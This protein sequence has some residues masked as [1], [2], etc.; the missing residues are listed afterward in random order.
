MTFTPKPVVLQIVQS[1]AV[2]AVV[3]NGASEQLT[4]QQ[5][6]PNVFRDP[7]IVAEWPAWLPAI[8]KVFAWD[9]E[10]NAATVPRGEV[11]RAED[12]LW[13]GTP[14]SSM[15]AEPGDWIVKGADGEPYPVSAETFAHLFDPA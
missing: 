11:W 13:I 3:W 8:S 9:H 12:T 6:D 15:K 7:A 2:E 1:S 4:T 14:E 5:T 10:I